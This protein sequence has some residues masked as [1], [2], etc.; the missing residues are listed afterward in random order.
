MRREAVLSTAAA[1]EAT[2]SIAIPAR[3]RDRIETWAREGYPIET[4]GLLIGSKGDAGVEVLDVVSARNLNVER[5]HDRF[6]LDPRDFLAADEK[7]RSQGLELVGCWHSHPDHPAR[8]SETDRQFAWAGWS[9]IIA[10]VTREGVQ[11]LRSFYFNGRRFF[12]QAMS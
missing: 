5:A 12:E 6:D 4:C 2:Q 9:Y 11:E 3:F 8:P 7:A 10:S 1:N